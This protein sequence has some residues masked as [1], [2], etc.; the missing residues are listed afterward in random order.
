[1]LQT[2]QQAIGQAASAMLRTDPSVGVD[3]RNEFMALIRNY[4]RGT[5]RTDAA[6]AARLLK[7]GEVAERLG[8]CPR[9]VDGLARSGALRRVVLPGRQRGAGYVEADV[10][11]LIEEAASA[12]AEGL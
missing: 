6:P 10:V 3:E 9:T 2:T 11:R 1:M 5:G 4:G 12:N 7:R 8:V